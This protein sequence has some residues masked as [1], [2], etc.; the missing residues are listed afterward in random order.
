MEFFAVWDGGQ[1][2]LNI[3]ANSIGTLCVGFG[4][5]RETRYSAAN[6]LKDD[7]FVVT[8]N[9][10]EG[11]WTL[12]MEIPIEKLQKFYSNITD[13]TFVS[14]YSFTGNF[15]KTGGADIT[16]NEH[17]GMWNEVDTENPDFHQPSYFG[18]FIME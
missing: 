3:E 1:S 2:Y 8:P 18:K 16:G 13:E 9:V 6:I 5:S 17:Y 11:K 14:G 15:Y 12:T 4:P 7:M 10:D